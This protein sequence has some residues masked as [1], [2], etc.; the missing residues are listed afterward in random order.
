MPGTGTSTGGHFPLFQA[1]RSLPSNHGEQ[2]SPAEGTVWGET[3]GERADRAFAGLLGLKYGWRVERE[4][5]VDG[6]RPALLSSIWTKSL[7]AVNGL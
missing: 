2:A 3:W 1:R 7:R 4:C 6:A 5:R